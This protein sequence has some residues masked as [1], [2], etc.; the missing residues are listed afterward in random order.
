LES[1]AAHLL[2]P[3]LTPDEL[4]SATIEMEQKIIS[5]S[6]HLPS[7]NRKDELA[8][9]A[10]RFPEKREIIFNFPAGRKPTT[11]MAKGIARLRA[12]VEGF[13]L[14]NFSQSENYSGITRLTRL[15]QKVS[16]NEE[17]RPFRKKLVES[18]WPPAY[19]RHA[20]I[21][22]DKKRE[23]R[24]KILSL[25]SQSIFVPKWMRLANA[26]KPSSFQKNIRFS[27]YWTARTGLHLTSA[28]AMVLTADYVVSR[29][30]MAIEAKTLE[31]EIAPDLER[32]K[33]WNQSVEDSLQKLKDKP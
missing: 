1:A 16:V 9:L 10:A 30:H 2:G 27:T 18:L 33:D 12:E 28:A 31:K 25:R 24:K 15:F 5:D 32:K 17:Q 8:W 11:F 20:S 4:K 6:A 23:A 19:I 22:Y 26:A 7:V 14:R 21:L 3:R 13:D 29:R